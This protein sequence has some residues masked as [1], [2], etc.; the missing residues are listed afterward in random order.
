MILTGTITISRSPMQTMCDFSIE[1]CAYS[2]CVNAE[3]SK[4]SCIE[5]NRA[6][7]KRSQNILCRQSLDSKSETEIRDTCYKSVYGVDR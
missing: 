7:L 1:S 4:L 6:T 5:S 2:M 3:K